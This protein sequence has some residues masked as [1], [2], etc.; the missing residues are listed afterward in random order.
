VDRTSSEAT[1]VPFWK[2]EAD[3]E[4]SRANIPRLGEGIS[5]VLA[6]GEAYQETF[7]V[8][9]EQHPTEPSA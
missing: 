6:S 2:N 8:V 9:H 1:C 7:E 4:A 3:E 5:H